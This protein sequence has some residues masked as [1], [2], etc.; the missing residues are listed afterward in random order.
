MTP[1]SKKLLVLVTYGISLYARATRES[2]AGARH[3][4]FRQWGRGR[5]R[6][7]PLGQGMSTPNRED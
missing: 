6:A 4:R 1:R 5:E 2:R 7:G 3:L